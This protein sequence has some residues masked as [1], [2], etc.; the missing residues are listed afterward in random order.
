MAEP[1]RLLVTGSRQWS[2][3]AL[4]RR[5]MD[6]IARTVAE[7]GHTRLV[8]VHGA[9]YPPPC[10]PSGIRPHESA[11]WLA[12]LWVALLTHPLP[13]TEEP[14]PAKWTAECR[15]SCRPGHRRERRSGSI[16]PAAGNYRNQLMVDLGADQGIGFP[17]D[18]SVGTRDCIARMNQAG[19]P[20]RVVNPRATTTTTGGT[21]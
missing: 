13:V 17:L 2:D 11:D 5:E 18:R 20:V 16:C 8:V 4:F 9:C 10:R 12:H 15:K 3:T 19:I 21:P 6:T 1:F 7:A 14:H